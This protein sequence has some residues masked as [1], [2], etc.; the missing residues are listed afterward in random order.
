MAKT[1]PVTPM[2]RADIIAQQR[3]PQRDRELVAD[4][5]RWIADQTIPVSYD[6]WRAACVALISALDRERAAH[7]ETERDGRHGAAVAAAEARHEALSEIGR[8]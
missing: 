2:L 1:A 6:E 5:R 7:R 4:A 8:W 3:Q